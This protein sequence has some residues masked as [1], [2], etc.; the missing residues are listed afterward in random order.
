M[1]DGIDAELY[2]RCVALMKSVAVALYMLGTNVW[3]FRSITGN[4]VDCTCT[5]SR[6]PRR[7]GAHV[8]LASV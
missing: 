7:K 5:I 4:H 8:I 1:R 3:A 2:T 6:W